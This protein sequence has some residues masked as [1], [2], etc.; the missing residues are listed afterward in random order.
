[1]VNTKNKSIIR[2]H[3]KRHFGHS[4]LTKIK[5]YLKSKSKSEYGCNFYKEGIGWGI[6]LSYTSNPNCF[7]EY[8]IYLRGVGMVGSYGLT[9]KD[10]TSAGKTRG[11]SDMYVF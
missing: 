2:E 8:L 5:E 3:I 4:N 1:M 10:I 11:C 9:K 7:A 6:E